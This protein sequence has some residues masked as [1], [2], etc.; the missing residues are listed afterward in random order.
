MATKNVRPLEPRVERAESG[1]PKRKALDLALQQIEKQF[2]KGAIMTLDENAIDREIEVISTGSMGLDLAL[3]IGGFPR[4]R[5]VE[6]YGPESSGKTT[7]ALHAIGRGAEG[8]RRR[9]VHRRRA[10][11]RRAV[12]ARARRRHRGPARLAARHRRAGARDRRHAGA[13]G[14]GRPRRDRLGRGARPARRDRGRDGRL[15]RGPAGAAHEPGAA[16]AHRHR[17]ASRTR[18]SSS[19]TRSA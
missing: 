15:A 3:G 5:I 2:G 1:S 4:G 17:L 10:R 16:Q 11:A 18:R 12:R 13:L 6:I 8:G 19:S 14:R 9:R 7:L